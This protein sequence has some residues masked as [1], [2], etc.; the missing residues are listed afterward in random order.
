MADRLQADLIEQFRGKPNI[1]ALLRVLETQLDELYA[2]FDDLRDLR[3]VADAMGNQLDGIGDIV[4]LTR[5]DAGSLSAIANPGQNLDD[6]VYRT[7]LFYKIWKNTN[8]C[9]Y[10]DIIKS[11][12]MFWDLPLYYS[13]DPDE[14]AT[15]ILSSDILK[16]EDNSY[17]LL[18]APMIKAAG[19]KLI[20]RTVTLADV[21]NLTIIPNMHYATI[22]KVELT[23]I[24][25]EH[26]F[27][28]DL[29]MGGLVTSIQASTVVEILPVHEFEEKVVAEFIG[30]SLS[31]TH[32]AD[33]QPVHEFEHETTLHGMAQSVSQTVLPDI[34]IIPE[35]TE[36]KSLEFV[37]QEMVETK[38][39]EI[40]PT[41]QFNA[42]STAA[43][44][45]YTVV[46]STIPG[47][48]QIAF[49]FMTETSVETSNHKIIKTKLKED[50][51]K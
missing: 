5:A 27:E 4:E 43:A 37:A 47:Y 28:K 40:I 32:L 21:S 3:N 49:G 42:V 36:E 38:L 19:V 1:E 50:K 29:F 31:Q 39:T 30:S 13:E 11:F 12:Q 14:P 6:E 51:K 25:P 48:E 46:T 35:L 22:S 34:V 2:F 24:L 26:D 15:M 45:T 10:P 44:N 41:H 8:T 9:T 20:V 18:T 23:E 17:K 16:P 7:F 33:L